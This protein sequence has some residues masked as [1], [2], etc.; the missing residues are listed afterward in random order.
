MT[1]DPLHPAQEPEHLRKA[2]R[3]GAKTRAGKP[4]QS[5]AVTGK[6]RC[7]MHGG[8]PGSGGPK[9]AHNG[10]YK[11]GLYTAETVASRRWLRHQIREVGTRFIARIIYGTPPEGRL[12]VLLLRMLVELYSQESP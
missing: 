4:C 3:C 11:H 10:N 9:G 5:P 1:N 6:R 8:A 2:V 12:C 7:R